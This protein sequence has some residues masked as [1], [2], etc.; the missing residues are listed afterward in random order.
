[1]AH[2][3]KQHIELL[4]NLY[5][6]IYSK[7][8]LTNIDQYFI[9]DVLFHDPAAT[10]MKK[11]LQ[12]LKELENKYKS[13]FPNKVTKINQLWE[14]LDDSIIIHWSC[15]GTHKGT[16]R[17]I[18]PSGKNFKIS[19]ISIYKFSG[20]KICEVNQQWDQLGLLEQLGLTMHDTALR[21]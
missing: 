21:H 4:N 7:G 5:E 9:S 15:Q 17:D 6:N 1:M 14:T 16:Y 13:A 19:G 10:H 12:G 18:P 8:N 11:G 3:N 20:N 2:A